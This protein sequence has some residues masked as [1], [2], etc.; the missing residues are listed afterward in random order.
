[1]SDGNDGRFGTGI[2]RPE[3]MLRTAQAE[4][5]GLKQVAYQRQ[6][7]VIDLQ[8]KLDIATRTFCATVLQAGGSVVVTPDEMQGP[9]SM[10]RRE[11]PATRAITWTV[12]REPATEAPPELEIVK[13]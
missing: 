8:V 4:I 10:G 1:M 3:V 11:D 7:E 9:F 6:L 2:L 13:G 12:E 5:N